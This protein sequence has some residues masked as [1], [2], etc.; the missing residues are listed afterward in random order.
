[1][2]V[3]AVSLLII[4][5]DSWH[6]LLYEGGGLRAVIVQNLWSTAKWSGIIGS[7][8]V[9]L[10]IITSGTAIACPSNSNS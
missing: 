2:L 7:I 9:G 8:G 1:M 3:C 10:M 4:A 5:G 6:M